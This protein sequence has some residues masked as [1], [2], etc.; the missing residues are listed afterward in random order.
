MKVEKLSEKT[1][2]ALKD[3]RK[4]ASNVLHNIT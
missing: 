1:V 4:D 2:K 3:L